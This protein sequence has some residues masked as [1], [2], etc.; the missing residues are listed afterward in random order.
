[1]KR[2]AALRRGPSGGNRTRSI[3]LEDRNAAKTPHLGKKKIAISP[4]Q[5]IGIRM[6]TIVKVVGIEPTLPAWLASVP[7]Q[8][9]T[10]EKLFEMIGTKHYQGMP[11]L[12]DNSK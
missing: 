3:G 12:L 2:N 11:L 5:K 7:P 4:S 6:Q 9:I 8:H 1:V 10:L